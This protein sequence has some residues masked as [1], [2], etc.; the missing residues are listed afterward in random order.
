MIAAETGQVTGVG[1]SEKVPTTHEP[2]AQGTLSRGNGVVGTGGQLESEVAQ[3]ASI[4]LT[5]CKTGQVV[6]CGQSLRVFAQAKPALAIGQ[7]I[8]PAAEQVEPVTVLQS[9]RQVPSTHREAPRGQV[10][11]VG[12]VM[13]LFGV[14]SPVG[15][16]L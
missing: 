8:K 6:D 4:H 11:W 2:S 7:V 16:R 14:H 3:V 10:T 12:Q 1:Q 5:G 9:V 13:T 15:Q